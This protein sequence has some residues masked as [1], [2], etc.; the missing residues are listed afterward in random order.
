M[1]NT[2]LKTTTIVAI[3][4]MTGFGLVSCSDSFTDLE[5]LGNSTYSNFWKTGQDAENSANSMYYYMTNENYFGDGWMWFINA[6]DDMITNRTKADA[7][8]IKNFFTTGAERE[9]GIRHIYRYGYRI[10]RRANDVLLNV[11]NI[12]DPNFSEAAK[13][14]ILGEAYFMRGFTNFYNSY[15]YGNEKMGVPIIN[16][17]NMFNAAGSYSRAASVL[18]NY[19]DIIEDL[20]KAV[21]LLPLFTSYSGEDYGRA[22]RDA[23]LAYIAKTYLYWAYYDSSKYADAVAAVDAVTN[24]G[25]G[26]AL[27]NT[28][29]PSMDYRLLH[30][31][32]TNWGSEYIW[33]SN[34]SEQSGCKTPG[35]M[36]EEVGW[37]EYNG[38]GYFAPTLELYDE[39]EEGDVRRGVT[40]LKFGDEFQ[41]F[42]ETKI[43]QST[44][45]Q[46]GFQFNKY[47]Y[48]YGIENPV[49]NTV[50]PKQSTDYN[51]P[52]CVMQSFF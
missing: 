47:M 8:N 1:K 18:E 2:I 44:N 11:P 17:E 14:R 9:A 33:S 41:Y 22:H 29:D 13:N 46:T 34:S 12:D 24:S 25:S 40:I 38:W 16:T 42:G 21:S 23:A 27:Y 19:A 52:V 39:F 5:P 37:G 36:L 50:G 4:C 43:Y 51:V 10:I 45:S 31:A 35:I 7:D 6:S 20:N 48:E 15:H 49:G 32:Q 28:G 30:S 26:R 3:L